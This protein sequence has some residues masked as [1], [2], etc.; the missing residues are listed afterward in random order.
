MGKVQRFYEVE[1]GTHPTKDANPWIDPAKV[2]LLQLSTVQYSTGDLAVGETWNKS[3]D[4]K[5]HATTSFL[6]AH[7]A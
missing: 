1:L 2:T 3:L 7:C 5:R 4:Q 6:S